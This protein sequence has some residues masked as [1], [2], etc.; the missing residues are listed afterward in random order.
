[1]KKQGEDNRRE[2]YSDLRVK[3][4]K[5]PC[6][7]EKG[8]IRASG[9]ESWLKTDPREPWVVGKTTP[10]L[11]QQAL[12]IKLI[13]VTLASDLWDYVSVFPTMWLHLV[14]EPQKSFLKL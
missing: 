2:Q 8:R 4:A 1:M 14:H 12:K 9:Q 7:T 6:L 5:V 13:V 11:A 3:R 10:S